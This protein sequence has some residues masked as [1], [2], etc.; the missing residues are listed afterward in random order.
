MV[1]RDDLF[2]SPDARSE[3]L[4]SS[5]KTVKIL[6]FPL[7]C[8]INVFGFVAQVVFLYLSSPA[9]YHYETHPPARQS[10]S[11]STQLPYVFFHLHQPAAY[12]T[13]TADENT[14]LL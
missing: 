1:E 3:V 2:S 12:E 5:R 11:Y 10:R 8:E 9:A 6:A 7:R 14:F 4:Q 13:T